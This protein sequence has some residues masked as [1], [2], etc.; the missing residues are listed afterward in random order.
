MAFS[1]NIPESDE[2]AVTICVP[3]SSITTSSVYCVQAPLLS[4]S[5]KM[6]F[7]DEYMV[8]VTWRSAHGVVPR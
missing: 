8:T 5:Y 1:D 7:L 6:R 4:I 2:T 3:G